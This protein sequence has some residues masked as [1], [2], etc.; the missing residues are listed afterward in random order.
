MDIRK[1]AKDLALDIS[2]SKEY[3]N[4]VKAKKEIDANEENK[5]ILEDF[6]KKIL[7]YQVKLAE[8]GKEDNEELE[9]I[10]S[11]QNIL[12]MNEDLAKYFQAEYSFSI[13][14][15]DV[16]EILEKTLKIEG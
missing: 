3:K 10:Q 6:Q 1:K 14:M 16:N 7:N 12:M 8:T 9:K 11:L 13:L 5:K 2:N 15:R 4:F